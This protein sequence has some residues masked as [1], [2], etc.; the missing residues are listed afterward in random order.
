MAA[1]KNLLHAIFG[2]KSRAARQPQVVF[3]SVTT[4]KW[5]DTLGLIVMRQKLAPDSVCVDVGC[6]IGKILDEMMRLAPQ[7]AFFAFEPLPDLYAGLK[8]RYTQPNVHLSNAALSDKQGTTSFN[9]VITNPAYSGI[10]KRKYDR[11]L[12]DDETITVPTARLDDVLSQAGVT[13][14]D[15]IKIDV[16]GAELLV[17]KGAEATLKRDKPIVIFEHGLGATDCYGVK[18]DD[19]YELLV[20]RCGMKISLLENFLLD[21]PALTKEELNDQFY[22]R[23]NYYFVAHP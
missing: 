15:L 19:V 2:R 13:K 18:P 9:H 7:G 22:S 14:V 12:E 6:H 17:L 5:Y 11:P 1:V 23:K 4:V 8:E 10:V 20:D 3:S 21:L 16:E